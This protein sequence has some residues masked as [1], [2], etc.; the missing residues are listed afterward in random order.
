MQVPNKQLYGFK[1]LQRL[2][3]YYEIPMNLPEN[4]MELVMTKNTLS[5]LRFLCS[6]KMKEPNYLEE[7][8]RYIH[9]RWD[10]N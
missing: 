9:L 4:Y 6:V 2:S 1:D 7:V 5:S 3:H 8:T 10:P